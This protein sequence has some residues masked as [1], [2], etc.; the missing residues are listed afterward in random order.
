MLRSNARGA[1]R[2]AREREVVK[3]EGHRRDGGP[4][5][6]MAVRIVEAATDHGKA[7]QSDS[8]RA[9]LRAASNGGGGGVARCASNFMTQEELELCLPRHNIYCY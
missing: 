8:G 2:E 5:P 4:A 1:R 6:D 3:C 7:C 9:I